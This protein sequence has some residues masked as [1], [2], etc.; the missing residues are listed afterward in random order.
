[1]QELPEKK[2]WLIFAGRAARQK[3]NLK[4]LK[5]YIVDA[6]EKSFLTSHLT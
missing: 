2:A 4:D 1:V 5:D 6:P 3:E